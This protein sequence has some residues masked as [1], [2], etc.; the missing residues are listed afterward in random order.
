MSEAELNSYRFNSGKEPTDEMLAHIMHEV[1]QEAKVQNEEATK[2]YF[3]NLR[4]EA[5][6]QQAQWAARI[7]EVK[8]W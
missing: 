8:K 7:N 1:A 6:E 3:E 4:K 5:E 2:K